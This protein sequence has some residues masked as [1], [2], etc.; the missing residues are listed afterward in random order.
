M[1]AAGRIKPTDRAVK[2]Y[3]A[4]LQAYSDQRVTHEGALETAFQQLLADTARH[5]GWMLV[6]KMTVK[7]GGRSIIPDGTV[8]D[9][10][11]LHRGYWEAKDTDDDLDGRDRKKIARGYPLTNTIFEDTRRAVLFQNGGRR[12]R[13]RPASA[14]ATGRS[15]QR[16]LSLHRARYRGLRAGGRRVQGA[17]A[18]AGPGPGRQDQSGPQR[19]RQIPR[20]RS[21]PSSRSARPRSIRTSASRRSTRCWSSTC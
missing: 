8:R 10:F 2:A 11:N 4:A 3:Y 9:E 1:P 21:R 18:R 20:P 17:R 15:A 14:A 19:Q 7:R 12:L 5:H 6:P 16:V 13:V